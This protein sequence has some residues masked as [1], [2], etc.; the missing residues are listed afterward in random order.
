MALGLGG[1]GDSVSSSASKWLHPGEYT[2]TFCLTLKLW[3]GQVKAGCGLGRDAWTFLSLRPSA[4]AG[5]EGDTFL[6]AR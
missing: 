4:W 1:G 2:V 6:P 5:R 3:H